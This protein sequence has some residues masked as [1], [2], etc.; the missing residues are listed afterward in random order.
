MLTAGS[1]RGAEPSLAEALRK[2]QSI[3]P[4]WLA[5][6][7]VHYDTRNPWKQARLHIRKLLAKGGPHR[8]E[9]I[10]LTCDY[11]VEREVQK[12]THE[13][14]MYLYL[15]GEYAWA[16]KVYEERLRPRPKG[17]THEYSDLASCYMKF[18]E[19]GKALGILKDALSQLPDP[20]WKVFNEA[21]LHAHI[22]DVYAR[23]GDTEN[24]AMHYRTAIRLF[25]KAKPKYGRHLLP[26]RIAKTQAK[27][28]LLYRDA[29][30][31]GALPDGIYQGMSLGYS[32]DLLA[33]VKIEGGR[34]VDIRVRHQENIEQGAT[35]I[36]PQR[37]IEKQDLR[38]D[39]VTGATVTSQAIIEATYRALQQAGL[40]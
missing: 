26:R 3:P 17:R 6:V 16:I 36:I 28:D 35:K 8:K 20:P 24:A 19:A 31:L 9:A 33:T 15:G 32:K 23:T 4:G 11:L 12:D 10:K 27:L 13:Y 1:A 14:P 21:K 7:P 40:K 39:A 5:D 18:G 2:V 37:I 29:L 34:I 30:N 38:I 22:G 25:G